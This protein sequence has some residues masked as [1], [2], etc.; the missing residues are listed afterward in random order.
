MCEAQFDVID[1]GVT[2]AE[3]FQACGIAAGIKV[4]SPD[5]ALLLSE[6]ATAVAGVFTTNKVFAAPVALCK[7]H[8]ADGRA[9][10]V[11]INSGCANACTGE[12]GARDTQAM[13]ASTAQVLDLPVD[14]VMVCSTGTIG[15]RLPMETVLSGI[16]QAAAALTPQG[17]P[18]AARAIMTTDTRP[19]EYAVALEI[20]GKR[21]VVGGMCKGAGMIAPNMATMLGF[22]T[23]DAAVDPAAWQALLKTS[24]D[25]SFNAITVDGDESTNDTVLAFANGRA[26]NTPLDASHA[27]WPVFSAAVQAVCLTLAHAIVK[28]GEGAT[29]FVTVTVEGAVDDADADL[30]ARAVANSLL[31]KTAVFGGDPNWGRVIA[32]VGYSGAQVDQSRIEIDFDEVAAVK[33]G[34]MAEGV[35]FE[36]LEKVYARPAFEVTVRLNLGSGS[37]TVYTCDVSYDY[38]KINAEY[39]T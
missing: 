39:M 22:L 14:E 29:K 21:V 12:P 5:M 31:V 37:R 10:A 28:D 20:E 24:V 30:A 9:R 16:K 11:I 2:A 15:K 38:V 8:V 25:A 17:G 36:M 3:G 6:G 4:D 1:G 23:T 13:A 18:D 32:A 33:G 35:A 26:D 34:C 7:R 19:K 27:D